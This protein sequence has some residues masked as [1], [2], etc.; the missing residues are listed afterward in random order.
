M[1]ASSEGLEDFHDR[2]K[3]I[4]AEL[5][6]SSSEV[7]SQ[8][9]LNQLAALAREWLRASSELRNSADGYL[10]PL[11]QY[12]L[13]MTEVLNSTKQRSRSTAYRARLKPFLDG[14]VDKIVVPLM[15][16]EGSPSQVAS[17]QLEGLFVD[18]VTH[19]ELA[20]VQEAARCSSQHCQRAAIIM[21]W[22]AGVARLHNRVQAAGFA[23]FNAA[24]LAV[25]SKKGQPYSRIMKGLVV[26]SLAELQRARDADL[27]LVGLELWS[28]DLQ[29]FEE[30]DRLLS[31]RNS[32]AHPGMFSPTSLDVRMFAEKLRTYVF[33]L[34]K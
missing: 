22:S 34:V 33:E 29:A 19:E 23:A 15:R 16:F 20:Y 10:P 14:F 32:A 31:I 24:A 28:Y 8:D 27:L 6:R 5:S 7:R 26:S 11:D 21:L 2:V 30:Q 12:D 9:M 4:D 13:A 17:R 3:A 18:A 25:A 1:I